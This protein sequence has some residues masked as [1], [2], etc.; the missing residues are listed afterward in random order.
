MKN[1]R[2]WRYFPTAKN[3]AKGTKKQLFTQLDH[4]AS[5]YGGTAVRPVVGSHFSGGNGASHNR[6]PSRVAEAIWS[7]QVL[8]G[9]RLGQTSPANWIAL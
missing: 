5:E 7:P 4:E 1:E 8:A 3:D 9:V 2:A 6:T